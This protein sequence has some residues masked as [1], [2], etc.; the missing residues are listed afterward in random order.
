[1][2]WFF[3]AAAILSTAIGVL[4]VIAGGRVAARPL[5][6]ASG[7]RTTAKFTSYYCWHLVTIAI[8]A[9]AVAFAVAAASEASR[10]VAMLATAVSGLF[11]AW[12]LVMI[13]TFRLS[14][15]GFPQWLLFL[16][17]AGLGLAGLTG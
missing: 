6:E 5:L 1:M 10:D 12:S 7:L 2:N 3:L 4:H 8:A 9:L 15:W 13:A 17:V 16:S 14:L 11:A